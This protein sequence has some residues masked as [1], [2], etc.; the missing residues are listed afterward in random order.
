MGMIRGWLAWTLDVQPSG[1]FQGS[2]LEFSSVYSLLFLFR[3]HQSSYPI[4]LQCFVA[5]ARSVVATVASNHASPSQGISNYGGAFATLQ[6]GSTSSPFPATESP[7]EAKRSQA[8][9][10]H[11][12]TCQTIESPSIVFPLKKGCFFSLAY[13]LRGNRIQI[14]P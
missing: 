1:D 9:N 12:Q 6:P 2:S 7:P 5:D 4:Q 13:R 3:W 11:C 14:S 8:T 10:R